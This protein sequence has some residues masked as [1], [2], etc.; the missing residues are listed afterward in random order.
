MTDN[1]PSLLVERRGPLLIV[2]LNRPEARNAVDAATAAQMNA[3]MDVLDEDDSLFIGIL[4]GSGGNFC[5]G[6][7]LKAAARGERLSND[8]RGLFGLFGRPPRKPLIAAV[9]ATPWVAAWKSV[10]PAT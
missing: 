5:T 7:D 3:A 10:W 6:G 1:A 8:D 9:E 2:T 4:T